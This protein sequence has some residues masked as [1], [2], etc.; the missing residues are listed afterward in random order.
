MCRR[1][2]FSEELGS[3]L[4]LTARP[5]W[6]KCFPQCYS[7]YYYACMN[8][9]NT[10]NVWMN[11]LPKLWWYLLDGRVPVSPLQLRL[12][13]VTMSDYHLICICKIGGYWYRPI[14]GQDNS[15]YKVYRKCSKAL[16]I[17]LPSILHGGRNILHCVVMSYKY[18]M[19]VRVWLVKCV[20][21]PRVCPGESSGPT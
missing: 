13:L 20:P 11:V 10:S 15:G 7:L 2:C 5:W 6:Q 18:K 9:F 19:Y 16:G 14:P 12:F 8:L 21:H 3:N 1:N 4:V 17:R